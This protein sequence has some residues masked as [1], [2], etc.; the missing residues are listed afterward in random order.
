MQVE[1][2]TIFITY[3][4]I[5]PVVAY[6]VGIFLFL[7]DLFT[8]TQN[9]K[10]QNIKTLQLQ[11]PYE[12][13]LGSLSNKD[14]DGCSF[15]SL[16]TFIEFSPLQIWWLL[17]TFKPGDFFMIGKYTVSEGQIHSIFTIFYV[18]SHNLVYVY[19]KNR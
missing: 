12:E 19:L 16:S 15:I 2:N 18:L 8:R 3:Q 1:D 11:R 17:A 4:S 13:L 6:L 10:T 5:G 9:N 7:V 14:S